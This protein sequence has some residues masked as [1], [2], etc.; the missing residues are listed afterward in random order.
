MIDVATLDETCLDSYK[1]GY[2]DLLIKHFSGEFSWSEALTRAVLR[3]AVRFFAVCSVPPAGNAASA[4]ASLMVCSPIVDQVVDALLLDSPLMIWME[5]TL[6]DGVRMV[7]IPAYAHGI[8]E[9]AITN[10]RYEFTVNLMLAAGYALD[11]EVIWPPRLLEGYLTC[12]CDNDTKDCTWG[13]H[14]EAD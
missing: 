8:S 13:V 12:G 5:R 14:R 9:P 7:H 11:R 4:E 3:D 10:L 1:P 6:F 2:S